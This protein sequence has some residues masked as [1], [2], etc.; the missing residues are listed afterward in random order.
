MHDL[1]EAVLNDSSGQIWPLFVHAHPDDETLQ[2]GALIA[3]CADHDIAVDVVTC[4]RGERGEV[5][6]GVL[7]STITSADLVKVREKEIVQACEIL[8]VQSH[9]WLGSPPARVDEGDVRIYTDSGMRWI[10]EGLAGP[11]DESDPSTFTAA[12][13]EEAASDL[14]HLVTY[15]GSSVIV[16]YDEQGSYGHPD[17]VRV[18][19]ICRLAS[20]MTG[21][22]MIEVASSEGQEGFTYIDMS[23]YADT[24]IAALASY[25][26]Q[27][28]VMGDHLIHVGG[29]RQ[30][31]PL[32]IGL[33][34]R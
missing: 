14:A 22:P 6:S 30:E 32:T 19:E 25:R 12:C 31:F 7:P 16:G 10:A 2:T 15:L 29:Q 17:H 8:R 28:T 3:W 18:H 34:L 11:G 9:Y 21:V 20:R 4:T 33:R 26:T 13:V 27:L 1:I 23:A 5:V 24:V